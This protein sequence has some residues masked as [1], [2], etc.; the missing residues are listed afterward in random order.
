MIRA[1]TSGTESRYAQ[2]LVGG[3]GI[4]FSKK[5]FKNKAEIIHSL[6]IFVNLLSN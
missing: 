2:V 6:S 1:C 4:G 3:Q 5:I